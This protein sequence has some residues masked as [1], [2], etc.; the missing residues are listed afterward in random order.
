MRFNGFCFEFGEVMGL[1]LDLGLGLG[2]GLCWVG[3]LAISLI[4]INNF[5]K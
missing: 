3:L 1:G 5:V 4:F 2:L